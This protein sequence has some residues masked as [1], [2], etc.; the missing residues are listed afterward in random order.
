MLV[1]DDT[2]RVALCRDCDIRRCKCCTWGGVT[3]LRMVGD[4]DA[5]KDNR[6]VR[7]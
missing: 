7:G 4:R 1:G 3:M 5:V 6:L 2:R